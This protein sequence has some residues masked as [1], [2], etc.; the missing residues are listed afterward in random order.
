MVLLLIFAYLGL[1]VLGIDIYH[2]EIAC[3]TLLSVFAIRDAISDEPLRLPCPPRC[4]KLGFFH[5]PTVIPSDIEHVLLGV[6]RG[7]HCC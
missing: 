1:A 4:P 6:L 2:F 5:T 3:G 7:A